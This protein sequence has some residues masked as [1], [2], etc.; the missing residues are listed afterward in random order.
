[1]VAAAGMGWVAAGSAEEALAV[2]A[3][4]VALEAISAGA[5]L[6]VAGMGRGEVCSAAVVTGKAAATG[7]VA[8]GMA[9]V[10]AERVVERMEA[11]G[12]VTA[13]EAMVVAETVE[14]VTARVVVAKGAVASLHCSSR[15]KLTRRGPRQ[16]STCKQTHL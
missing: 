8:V 12:T 2:G 16:W 7:S 6:V 9:L 10:V 4:L 1:M 13:A 14:G 15:H 11:G 3:P 5:Q